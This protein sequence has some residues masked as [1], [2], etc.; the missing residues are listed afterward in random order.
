MKT[1]TCYVKTLRSL[2]F[3]LFLITTNA[4]LAQVVQYQGFGA[5]AIGGSNSP[6]VYRVTNLNSSGA[7]SLANGIGSNRTIV[8]D[9]S[10]TIIGRFDISNVSYMTI[11]ATGQNITIN[12]NVNGDGISFGSGTHHCILKG[13]HVTNAGNDGINVVDGANNILITN[14]TSYGNRDGNIDIAGGTNVTVQYCLLGGGNTGWSGAMLVTATN[15]S[16]HHNLISPATP[17]E[18]GERCPLVHCNYS[19][20]GNPNID[21]RNNVVWNWGRANGTGS[22]YGTAIAYNA[23]GNV[24]NNY[25]RSNVGGSSAAQPDDGYGSN[26]GRAHI[27]G[28]VSGN[29]GVNPNIESNNA[30]FTIPTAAAVTTQDAC[31]AA[32]LVLANAGPSP[33]NAID[34]ALIA[35][36]TL[37]GCPTGPINQPPV[38]NAG[39]DITLAFPIVATTLNGSATDADGTIASYSWSRV[40]GPTTFTIAN[41]T[42]AVT[43]LTGLLQGTYVFRLTAT[44]NG[45]ATST[46]DV[47]VTVNGLINVAPTS[48]AGPDRTLTLPTNST[49]L[50]GSG[51]DADGSISTYA[52]TRVSGP[53]TFTLGTAN[54]AVTTL[55]NLVQGTYVFRLTVTD[56]GGAT[57]TDNV[58]VIVNPAP[59]QAPTANAGSDITITLPVNSTSLTGSGSDPDGTIAS[60]AWARVSGPTT[61]TLGTPN[62]AS[63]TLTGL[64]QGTYVFRLTVTDNSGAA[65][66]DNV[67][68]TVNAA[69]NQAPTANAGA[70]FTLTLPSNSTTLNGGGADS[71]GTIAGYAWTRISGPTT[72]TLGT[73]T[74]ATTT[75]TGL[76]QGTY[77]F[78]LTV[79]DNSGATAIDDVTVTV[80]AAANVA[81]TANAGNNIS[82]TLPANST[83]LSG[84]GADADGAISSYAWTW[85]SGPATYTL[86][87]ANAAATSL[88]GLVQGTYVFR[89]TVTD[90]SGAT[91]TDDV[92]VTVNAAVI[93]N[94]P[95]I[96]NAGT[97]IVISIPVNSTTLNGSNSMDL[98]GTISSYAWSYVSGPATYTIASASAATTALSGLVQGTYVFRLTVT[99]N[100][101]ATDLDNIVITVNAAGNQAPAANAG[102]NIILT[103]PVNSTT[104]SG[105]GTDLDGSI[106]SYAWS[107]VSGPTTFTLASPA[108]A[109][110]ALT[111]LVQGTYVFRLTVM[112]NGG[113]TGTDDITVTVNPAAAP[114]QLPVAIAGND[115]V[116]TLPVNSTTLNGSTSN[117]P[118]GSIVSY[119][120]TRISGPT[121]YTFT[122]AGSAATGLNNLVQ[123]TY[124]FRLTVTDNDGASASDDVTVTVNAAANQ[125]PVA[126]AGN[127][128]VLTLPVNSTTLSGSG[129]DPDGT[130]TTYAWARVSGP[131]AFSLT[132][133][134]AASTT[135]T[136]LVQGTYVF[137]LT[138]T[139]NSGAT[140]TDNITVTVNA[141]TPGNTPPT[142]N[143]GADITITLPTNSTTLSGSGTDPGGTVVGYAWTHVSGPATYILTN[144]NAASTSLTS[145]VQGTY[146]FRLTVTDNFGATASDIVVVNVLQSTTANQ[147]PTARTNNDI[148]LTLPVN[149]T[150]LT[151][152]ASTDADGIITGYEWTQM[153]GPNAAAI[154]N[155]LG[156]NA[157]VTGLT[158]GQYVFQLKVTDDDGATSVKTIQVNVTNRNGQGSYFNIYPNPT[159]GVLNIQYFANGNGEVRVTIFDASRKL[160]QTRV[161]TKDQVVLNTSVDISRLQNGVYFLLLE[162]P[163]GKRVSGKFVKM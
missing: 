101:G 162:L 106:V 152:T 5:G 29:T 133:A 13:V 22:G 151:G 4:L 7:G 87:T 145:L 33:R 49:T 26:G 153:S 112:D 143:A 156:V 14:C 144:A 25:Y 160:V 35:A 109:S 141:A 99:D 115:I 116:M 20:V 23:T 18:V 100:L 38:V 92:N 132:N 163:N 108:A 111:G 120:W 91:G 118:D 50:N 68:V 110:T 69:P 12:N 134:S 19:P 93:T 77:V 157:Q 83:T 48:N 84:S 10:G 149:Y 66:T 62:A 80:N 127:D 16:V 6:T 2:F 98:D 54:A 42:S 159:P 104:L 97:N 124:V 128:I 40:S 119:S 122:S 136:G 46:D 30:I 75:L 121:A 51:T 103:L 125:A 9:V 113:S 130:I 59:N 140:A 150:S 76:V 47:T 43:A 58:T 28:N 123:G 161:V 67:T 94:Q 27:A 88:T 52:W 147:A 117:D 53:T 32:A 155:G 90:N 135:L 24:I 102:N 158:L 41:I 138:V 17:G 154:A 8:F 1:K 63:T 44:D 11:D 3:L 139:D 129:T 55:T 96:A 57:A 81:P 105:A 37:T 78:R 95:P 131:T 36:V 65:V 86:G 64:V 39:T 45:G 126:N 21:F 72:F 61:F 60:Y 114:N 142:A 82:L 34:N 148:V 107:R 137:R 85:I 73:P 70:N 15:V 74:A 71:D 146:Q 31:T 79:T 89:L 56:N